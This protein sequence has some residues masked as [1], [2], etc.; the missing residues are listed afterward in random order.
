M[1]TP[2]R[3]LP[4]TQKFIEITN[5]ADDIVISSGGN[6]CLVI[7]VSATNFALLSPEEQDAKIYT[8]A[9]LLNS[10]SFPIQIVIRSKKLDITNYLKLLDDEKNKTQNTALAKQIGLYRDFVKELVKVNTVLDKKFYVVIPYSSLEK[11]ASGAREALKSGTG[12]DSFVVGARAS[13]HSKAESIHTQLR[14]LNLKAR[15]L[16]E[17]QLTKL[18]YE[19]FNDSAINQV[20]TSPAVSPPVL[21]K[22][23][24]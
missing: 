6:A 11:G 7:E 19:I 10:L 22:E 24:K 16:D 2:A 3:N 9:S 1:A 17:E 8:Y 20:K 14:R 15:T 18:F 23:V 21:E 4:S 5:I 13:L 12:Q